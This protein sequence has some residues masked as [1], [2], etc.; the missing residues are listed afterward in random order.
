M[1]RYLA[2]PPIAIDDAEPAYYEPTSRWSLGNWG[3]AAVA[4]LL[5]GETTVFILVAITVV[6]VSVLGM[7]A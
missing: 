5:V 4:W 3:R 6:P 7:G 2:L 1:L